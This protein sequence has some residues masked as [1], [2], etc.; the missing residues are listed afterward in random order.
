MHPTPK[1]SILLYQDTIHITSIYH[2]KVGVSNM[3]AK[4][5]PL[6]N[7]RQD[8]KSWV[9]ERNVVYLKEQMKNIVQKNRESWEE[10]TPGMGRAG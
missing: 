1:F 10:T 5:S 4:P 2:C 6:S 3:S 7:N 8:M 9:Q